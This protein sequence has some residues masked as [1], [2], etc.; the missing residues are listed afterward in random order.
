MSDINVVVVTGRLTADARQSATSTG[1]G[2]L[3]FGVACNKSVRN[4]DTD[5]WESV[6]TYIDCTW[7]CD[8]SEAKA[9]RMLKGTSV[10]VFGE[11]KRDQWQS[12]DGTR[13]DKTIINVRSC[14]AYQRAQAAAPAGMFAPMVD[15]AWDSNGTDITSAVRP[16][17]EAA[18]A[19]SYDQVPYDDCDI[20]FGVD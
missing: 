20:P 15:H 9:A 14:E 13:H 1:K 4:K 10:A 2:V 18:Q 7:F 12:K 17:F 5:N 16:M 11:L 3:N 19:P 6:P 8:N